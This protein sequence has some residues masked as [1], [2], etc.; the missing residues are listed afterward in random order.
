MSLDTFSATGSQFFQT[1]LRQV[2]PQELVQLKIRKQVEHG[3]TLA[4]K[5]LLEMEQGLTLSG[6]E[7]K[8]IV[9]KGSSMTHFPSGIDI[10]LN[11]KIASPREFLTPTTEVQPIL[12][13]TD[14]LV[15]DSLDLKIKGEAY[16]EEIH[17][18]VGNVSHL[19]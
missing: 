6:A 9:I 14:E 1:E 5:D 8:E 4:L 15:D 7:I 2:E 19:Q 10:L 17:I 11:Q 3:T 16:I 13:E 12:V 18:Q